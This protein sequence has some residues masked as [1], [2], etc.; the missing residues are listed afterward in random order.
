MLLDRYQEEE[1]FWLTTLFG[2]AAK[3]A[4]TEAFRGEFVVLEGEL[5]AVAGK[6]TPPKAVIRQ[7]V[8]LADAEKL[9]MVA[10]NFAS[11]DELPEFLTRFGSDLAPGCQ[12]IFFIDNLGANARLEVEGQTYALIQFKEGVVW[13]E[14][15]E[16]FYLDKLD[17][18]GLSSED[19]VAALYEA[20]QSFKPDY[21]L[22]SL[23]EVLASRTES[24]REVFGAV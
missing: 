9:L 20:A 5:K 17:L 24:R 8:M 16:L 4:G 12:P 7:C 13:N 23:D 10:G 14:L 1:R 11:V 3:V 6:R 18:K 21:P 19:K 15:L 22:M 2:P